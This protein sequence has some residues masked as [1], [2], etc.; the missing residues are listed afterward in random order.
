MTDDGERNG[1]NT[2]TE[3]LTPYDTGAVAEPKPWVHQDGIDPTTDPA[4]V[5]FTAFGKVDFD[6][7]EG[8]TLVA[9]LRVIPM[10]GG[11]VT[12]EFGGAEDVT[13]VCTEPD[14][15]VRVTATKSGNEETF[16]VEDIIDEDGADD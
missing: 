8:A 5:D 15:T 13:I 3:T 1:R 6:S 7:E 16:T 9:G 2:V 11:G 10:P 14:A 12:I 4:D